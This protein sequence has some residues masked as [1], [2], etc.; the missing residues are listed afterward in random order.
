MKLETHLENIQDY[1][2]DVGGDIDTIKVSI[3]TENIGMLYEMLSKSIYSNPIGSIVRELVSNC[4]DSHIEEAEKR[5]IEKLEM[6]V[7]VKGFQEEQDYYIGFEDFG[8][9]LSPERFRGIYLKYMSSTKR[10]SNSQLGMFGLG[11]KSPFSYVDIFYIRTRY[12]SIEYYYMMSKGANGVPEADLMY[13]KP[14]TECNGTLV[15]FKLEGGKHRSRPY[16]SMYDKNSK[17]PDYFKFED[18]I[19]NQLKY[20]D[21]VYVEDFSVDNE[22]KILEFNTFKYRV[23][24]ENKEMHIL[25]GK[26]IYPIDWNIIKRPAI[27]IPIGVKLEIGELIITPNRESIRYNDEVISIINTKIDTALEEIKAL[28]GESVYETI[29]ALLAAQAQRDKN[30]RLTDEVAL[31]IYEG[32]YGYDKKNNVIRYPFKVSKPIFQPF[33]GTPLIIPSNPYFL[34][35]VIGFIRN[36]NYT[37][38]KEGMNQRNL[39]SGWNSVYEMAQKWKVYRTKDFKLSKVKAA[40]IQDGVIIAKN[41]VN[42]KGYIK[43]GRLNPELVKRFVDIGLQK[44]KSNAY[45]LSSLKSQPIISEEFN[46]IKLYK[47]Y[48]QVIAKEVLDISTSYDTLEVPEEF[49]QNWMR[50]NSRSRVYS[51]NEELLCQELT[52]G[53]EA[54]KLV[55]MSNFDKGLVIYGANKNK[56]LLSSVQYILRQRK[57]FGRLHF[58][59]KIKGQ[60]TQ[61]K[62]KYVVLV[63]N[64]VDISK[65]EGENHIH[66]KDFINNSK[67]NKVFR[68]QITAYYI[69]RDYASLRLDFTHEYVPAIKHWYNKVKQFISD[70]QI[71]NYE[72]NNILKNKLVKDLIQIAVDSN[73]LI[74]EYV[75]I[76]YNLKKIQEDLTILKV[77]AEAARQENEKREVAS[78]FIKKGYIVD[79]Y[80][81]FKPNEEELKWIKEWE[82]YADYTAKANASFNEVRYKGGKTFKPIKLCQVN[83]PNL[84]SNKLVSISMLSLGMNH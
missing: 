26:V 53:D 34:F 28:D 32:N 58:N 82:Q 54:K 22:Y 59:H 37:A 27:N 15:K 42:A 3:D 1:E 48:R 77:A 13:S 57:T 51:N 38:I 45:S 16:I 31:P 14:T 61:T 21:D 71:N 47:L 40:F 33:K 55:K 8:I 6:P 7:V 19:I 50:L 5:G 41:S 49:K 68:E 78:Y 17:L 60:P 52:N 44:V 9:G 62:N 36:G 67:K 25:L 4:F 84:S 56:D 76:V 74:K 64:Q 69:W 66:I 43:E 73:L 20:F 63:L 18:E 30:V 29:P 72:I 24:N 2:E 70:T 10:A 81:T 12:D 35:K 80:Y 23:G 79:N 65:M 46:K 83:F 75:D 11:S 39:P